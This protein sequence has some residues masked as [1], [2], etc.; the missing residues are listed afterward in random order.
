VRDFNTPS[1]PIDRSSR[2]KL[3]RKKIILEL[4]DIM[5]QMDL[6]GINT[7]HPNTKEYTFFSAPH[8][9]FCK[10]T[11]YLVTKQVLIESKKPPASC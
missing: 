9:T 6:T 11:T 7:F 2:Q 1:L 10:L 3:N 5:N 8:G 4:T